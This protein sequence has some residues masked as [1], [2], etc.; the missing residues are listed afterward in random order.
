[1][2][3]KIDKVGETCNKE[4]ENGGKEGGGVARLIYFWDK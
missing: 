4:H 2:N 3:N 1:M